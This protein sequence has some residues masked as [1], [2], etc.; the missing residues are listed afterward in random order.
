MGEDGRSTLTAVLTNLRIGVSGRST[1]LLPQRV[2][3]LIAQQD[4]QSEILIGYIQVAIALW[5]CTLYVIAPKPIDRMSDFLS[6]VPIAITLLLLLSIVRLVKINR[7]PVSDQFIAFSICLDV[8]L[9]IGVIWSFHIQYGQPPAFSLKAPTFCYLFVFVVVRALRFDPKYVIACGLAAA[10]G[11]LIL[12]LAVI[13]T[14][15]PGTVTRSFVAYI[16]GNH[17]LIGAEIDK[18]FSLLVVTALLALA[19][20]QAQRTLAMAT[21]EGAT[22]R[23]ITRFLSS[24]VAEGIRRAESLPEAGTAVDRTA[25]IMMLDIRGF[26]TMAANHSA[27]DV[28][29][30]LTSLHARIV[31]IVRA[32][33]GVIDKFLGDGIMATF[34]AVDESPTAAADALRALE[35]ILSECRSWEASLAEHNLVAPLVVNAAVTHGA[36]LFATIGTG[37]RL[38]ATVIGDVVNLA[39]KLEKHN[40]VTKTRALISKDLADAAEVQGCKPIQAAGVLRASVVA[41]VSQ[42]ID[43]VYWS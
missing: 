37:D 11:W 17:V 8:A 21:S 29:R 42:P 4:R 6:P 3:T 43:L 32:N 40:K 1:D 9:L 27:G 13:Q 26:T 19:A 16:N 22:A 23:E 25:A 30:I 34:G 33:G 36:V 2:R 39:A 18:I 20:G 35:L 10:V 14:S 28:V 38:E 41:G 15:E 5:F 24:G 12:T 31:P 7:G